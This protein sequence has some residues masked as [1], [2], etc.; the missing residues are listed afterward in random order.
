[1]IFSFKI[2]IDPV[3]LEKVLVIFAGTEE[4]AIIVEDYAN[5]NGFNLRRRCPSKIYGFNAFRIDVK[6]EN[7]SK[8]VDKWPPYKIVKDENWDYNS[9]L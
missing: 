9:A 3:D 7:L 2:L 1:M 6:G 8:L 5:K 4:E